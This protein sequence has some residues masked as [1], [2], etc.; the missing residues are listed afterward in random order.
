[1]AEVIDAQIRIKTSRPN[2]KVW[3]VNAEGFYAGLINTTYDDEGYLCF[4][5]GDENNPACYYLIV[6]D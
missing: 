4:R 3:G 2:L 1:M 5:V 6:Q